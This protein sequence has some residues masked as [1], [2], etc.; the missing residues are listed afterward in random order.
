MG[1][2]FSFI[3]T[4]DI[5]LGSCLNSSVDY[6][7]VSE[8]FK[9][10][11]LNAFTK[12]CNIAITRNVDFLLISGDLYESEGR[13]VKIEK[14]FIDECRRLG[15]IQVYVIYGNH[16]P[17]INFK[18][19]FEIPQ[20]VHFFS[21]NEV[22]K[23]NFIKDEKI[24]AVIYGQ[25]YRRKYECN[26]IF[27]LI[28]AENDVFNIVL[29]H[30][31]L[32]G[33]KSRYVPCTLNELIE[34]KNI[35]YWA[36]GHI[37]AASILNKNPFCV[38][39]GIP[40]GRDMGEQG[41]KGCYFARV[42]ES[43]E[44]DTEFI[45]ISEVIW[46]K[47]NVKIPENED[48]SPK[49]IDELEDFILDKTKIILHDINKNQ[50]ELKGLCLK[51]IL[52]GS[53]LIHELL[54][55]KSDEVL[56]QIKDDL[57]LKL[58]KSIPFIYTEEIFDNTS[59][60]QVNLQKLKTENSIYSAI[61]KKGIECLQNEKCNRELINNLGKVWSNKSDKEELDY[62]CFYMNEEKMNEIIDKAQKMIFEKLIKSG[63]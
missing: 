25:S 11:V 48:N 47:I 51:W 58:C 9:N 39:P 63:E 2:K 37:H 17:A 4:A 31:Q 60:L 46:N 53:C 19:L 41:N 61:E 44:I 16:D 49:N 43:N 13:S 26:K 35:N 12:I 22:E 62:H 3:H 10:A 5:H 6:D 38:F 40:Q 30:T 14:F 18:S 59:S 21:S 54:S 24:A 55:D 1:T 27:S 15:N 36:L 57:N 50:D 42:N 28:N 56:Q 52:E 8:V 34:I 23:I 32:E 20:N 33:I 7:L 29:L 45:N